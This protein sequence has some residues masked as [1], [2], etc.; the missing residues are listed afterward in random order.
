MLAGRGDAERYRISRLATD[1]RS[2]DVIDNESTADAARR[3]GT[4]GFDVR[5]QGASR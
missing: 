5:R 4:G 2:A 3:A 1:S